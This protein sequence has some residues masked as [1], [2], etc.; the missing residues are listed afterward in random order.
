MNILRDA[1]DN[2]QFQDL[3]QTRLDANRVLAGSDVHQKSVDLPS[4]TLRMEMRD[5]RP[6]QLKSCVGFAGQTFNGYAA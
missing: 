4:T 5:D 2:D 1:K 6:A 3:C